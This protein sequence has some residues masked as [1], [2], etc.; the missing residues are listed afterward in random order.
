MTGSNSSP[1]DAV[2]ALKRVFWRPMR[3]RQD[4]ALRTAAARALT[5]LV[6]DARTARRVRRC[7]GHV[8]QWA[9]GE[10][11]GGARTD[12]AALA[13]RTLLAKLDGAGA[14]AVVWQA[15]LRV[16]RMRS[17]T[18]AERTAPS[19]GVSAG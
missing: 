13:A 1:K 2:R 15:R 7:R 9:Q 19:P 17:S 18:C 6:G 3:G 10:A 16:G 12:D 14:S 11:A 8:M 4:V 5:A